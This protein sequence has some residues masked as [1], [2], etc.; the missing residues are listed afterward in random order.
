MN[1]GDIQ[2][3][4][5]TGYNPGCA[6]NCFTWT[7]DSELGTLVDN[8]DYT[9]T[10]TAPDGSAGIDTPVTITLYCLEEE[11]DSIAIDLTACIVT[12][13]YD[14]LSMN[15]L[16]T[17]ILTVSGHGD[18]CSPTIY[19]WA[20]DP[21]SGSLVD[22]ENFTATYTA[23]AGGAGCLSP[24]TII[25]SCLEDVV[26]DIEISIN[27]CPATATIGHTTHQMAVNTTQ[28]LTAVPG[29]AGCGTPT[30]D[31]TVTANCGTLSS[32]TGNT[33]IYTAP[34]NNANCLRNPTITL[35][36]GG[37]VMDTLKISVNA[38]ASGDPAVRWCCTCNT[39]WCINNN[40]RQCT[41]YA[42]CNGLPWGSGTCGSTC[43]T[44]ACCAQSD[45]TGDTNNDWHTC[46]QS[47]Y[48]VGWNDFRD[49]T[50]KDAGC[51]PNQLL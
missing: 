36:C 8:E 38:S 31:W 28:T 9:A 24:V 48:V 13:G 45:P 43:A 11:A 27:A 22:N 33:V 23:P 10:Y 21:D 47:G 37:T 40:I 7:K 32:P 34:A 14:S 1:C 50:M 6:S 49:Q 44:M 46:A 29:T 3:L 19:T 30:Y 39:T 42:K 17:Q 18:L 26:D 5:V 51:C 25:L 20:L 16:A 12:I 41:W 15:C 35:S 2:V 4:L